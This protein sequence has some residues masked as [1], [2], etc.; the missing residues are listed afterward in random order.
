MT[1]EPAEIP[2]AVTVRRYCLVQMARVWLSVLGEPD[3]SDAL[4]MYQHVFGSLYLGGRTHTHRYIVGSFSCIYRNEKNAR[5]R[6]TR[7][8]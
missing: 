8:P 6:R 1:S 5:I 2:V 3:S 4:I 7:L